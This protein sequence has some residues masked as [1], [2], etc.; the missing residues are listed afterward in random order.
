MNLFTET[1]KLHTPKF[2]MSLPPAF[3]GRTVKVVVTEL[4]VGLD[5]PRKHLSRL[6]RLFRKHK[7][8]LPKGYKFDREEAYE[9]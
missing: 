7:I 8:H 6:E 4:S 1:V 2:T 9:R 5:A 3:K